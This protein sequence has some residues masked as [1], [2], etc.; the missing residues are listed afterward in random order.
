MESIAIPGGLLVAVEG[1][2]GAGKTTLVRALER[3]L[4]GLG[5]PVVSGKEPTQGVYGQ[6]LRDTASTGRLPPEDE[7][8]LL[9]ADR[10]QHVR[11]VIA[12]TL[13]SGG[14]VL[15]DRFFYS[16]IAYQGAAGLDPAEVERRNLAIAPEPDLVLLLDL[17]VD[18]GLHRI[19]ARGDFANAFERPATLTAAKELFHAFLPPSPLG[20]V[21]DATQ[22]AD[23]VAQEALQHLVAA[24]ARKVHQHH[25]VSEAGIDQLAGIIGRSV[26]SQPQVPA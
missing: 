5:V 14:V 18:E 2:D 24:I 15:L 3:A 12:P 1:I 16:N 9:L 19:G 8:A 10:E 21:I 4:T 20:V 7:L 6:R 13:Q 22:P 25:G 17:P 11:D 23:A 26:M